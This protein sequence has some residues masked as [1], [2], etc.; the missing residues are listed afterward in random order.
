VFEESFL[1]SVS[2][3]AWTQGGNPTVLMVGPFNKRK[4]S[5]FTGNSTRTIDAQA[6]KLQAAIDLYEDD[7][8]ELVVTANRFSRD[9]TA[10]VIDP[11]YWSIKWLRPIFMTPLSKTGDAEKRMLIGEWTLCAKQEASSGKI[12][13]L[14]TS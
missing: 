8:G 13:D 1:K 14:T 9:R 10:M 11:E 2:Q 6:K 5:G 12:A 3:A 7:F 4:V